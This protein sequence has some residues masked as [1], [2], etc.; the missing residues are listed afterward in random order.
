MIVQNIVKFG[1]KE[2]MST[3]SSNGYPIRQIETGNVYSAATDRIDAGYTYEEIL[4]EPQENESEASA[5]ILEEEIEL[6]E[7][8][9]EEE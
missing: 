1:G 3:H 2:Y 7:Q 5:N 9:E 6:E 4:P 8:Q